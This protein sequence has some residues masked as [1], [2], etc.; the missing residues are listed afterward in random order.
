MNVEISKARSRLDNHVIDPSPEDCTRG[1]LAPVLV[2]FSNFSGVG[3]WTEPALWSE[4][5]PYVRQRGCFAITF[6]D[7]TCVAQNGMSSCDYECHGTNNR[8]KI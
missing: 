4:N 8:G 2:A 7:S 3:R 6:F 1:F 5:Q